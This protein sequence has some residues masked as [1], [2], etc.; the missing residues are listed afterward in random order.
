MDHIKTVNGLLTC[1]LG[2]TGAYSSYELETKPVDDGST[3]SDTAIKLLPLTATRAQGS[4]LRVTQKRRH[5][6]R[7]TR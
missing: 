5:R 7:S 6:G 3:R 1:S 2:Q 4:V